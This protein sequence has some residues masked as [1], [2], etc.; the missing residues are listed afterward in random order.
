MEVKCTI[1]AGENGT[2]QLQRE[3]GEQLICVRYRYDR[4]RQKRFKTIELIIEEKDWT[5]GVLVPVEK[6]VYIRIDYGEREL[7][8]K[9]KEAGG[10]WDK[11]RKAWYVSYKKVIE[12]GLDKRIL[13]EEIYF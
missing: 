9:I 6:R 12:L 3:Y 4:K 10:F 1:P 5:P 13:D 2:K 11:Q 8:E 7:R